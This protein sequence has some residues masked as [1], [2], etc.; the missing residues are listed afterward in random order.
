[1]EKRTF[2]TC[3]GDFYRTQK[4]INPNMT[5]TYKSKIFANLLIYNFHIGYNINPF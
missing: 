2:T 5:K 1:M 4:D 3:N